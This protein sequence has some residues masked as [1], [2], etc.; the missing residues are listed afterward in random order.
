MS[1]RLQRSSFHKPRALVCFSI[2]SCAILLASGCAEKRPRAFPWAT[3]IQVRPTAASYQP[4]TAAQTFKAA[5]QFAFEIPA[6]PSALE[7]AR[8]EPPRPRIPSTPSSESDAGRADSSEPLLAPQLTAQELALA[9][10]QTSESLGIAERN[11]QRANSRNLNAV[12]S[13]LVSKVS[14]FVA[15]SRQAAGERDWIRAS[16]LAKK[17]E[18]L[19]EELV[20]SL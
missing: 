11:L 10:R 3:A 2:A 19:S 13:D 16:N 14:S 15:Q 17:A 4:F 9:Q 20:N 8:R 18:V 5:P 6:P 12:Q 7:G 1:H